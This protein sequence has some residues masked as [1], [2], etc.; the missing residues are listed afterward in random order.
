MSLADYHY[1][2]TLSMKLSLENGRISNGSLLEDS[3]SSDIWPATRDS[4]VSTQSL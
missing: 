1:R 2:Q 4:H 3:M